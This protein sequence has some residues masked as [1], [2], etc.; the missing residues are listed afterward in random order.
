[1]NNSHTTTKQQQKLQKKDGIL[2]NKIN[3]GPLEHI[4]D[5]NQYPILNTMEQS[6][7]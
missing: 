6:P 2:N 1:V 7:S 3:C 5:H 4:S